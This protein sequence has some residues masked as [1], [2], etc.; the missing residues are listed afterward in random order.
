MPIE[1][2][3]DA[4]VRIVLAAIFSA[5]VGLNREYTYHPAGLRTH[6]LVGIGSALFTTLSIY[7]F[8]HGDIGRV[9]SQIVVGIGFLGAGT[10]IE[11][12]PDKQVRGLTTAAGVWMVAAIGMACGTSAYL[13]AAVAT[14]FAWITLSLLGK[15]TKTTTQ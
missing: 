1:A 4:S 13:V 6:M 8:P 9:A 7:A 11:N 3:L 5:I 15:L 2:Q 14:I 12:T 10:I